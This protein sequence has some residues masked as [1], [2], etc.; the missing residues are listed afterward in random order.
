[1]AAYRRRGKPETSDLPWFLREWFLGPALVTIAAVGSFMV[2]LEPKPTAVPQKAATSQK[3]VSTPEAANVDTLAGQTGARQTQDV[4]TAVAPSSVPLPEVSNAVPTPD[5]NVVHAAAGRGRAVPDRAPRA[6][7]T[8]ARSAT[9]SSATASNATA[10]SATV[11]S[12]TVS[13]AIEPGATTKSVAARSTAE[14]PIERVTE[15]VPLRYGKPVEPGELLQVVRIPL[16]RRELM[17]M[18]IPIPPDSVLVGV[19]ADVIVGEDGMAKAIRL[20]Y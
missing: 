9:V 14:S 1:M 13:S 11:S 5:D 2:P 8:A 6:F 15:F 12:A 3:P 4:Q 18:G 19:K 16:D 17:R 20:V 7:R 10:S